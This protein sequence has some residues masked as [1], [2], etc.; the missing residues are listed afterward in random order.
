MTMAQMVRWAAGFTV[1]IGV[2]IWLNSTFLTKETFNIYLGTLRG[3][4]HRIETSQETILRKVETIEG[5]VRK[6]R[7]VAFT[8]INPPQH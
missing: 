4:I 5:L 6:Q 3:D 8:P 2:I 7:G 1:G